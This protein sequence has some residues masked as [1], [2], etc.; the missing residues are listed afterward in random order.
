LRFREEQWLE[1]FRDVIGG[2]SLKWN[3]RSQGRFCWPLLML[4]MPVR[5]L[6]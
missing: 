2:G 4:R 3:R 6:T 5:C 1:R